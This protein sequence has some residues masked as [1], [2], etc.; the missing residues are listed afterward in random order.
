ML[1]GDPPYDAEAKT[2]DYPLIIHPSYN[3]SLDIPVVSAYLF[4]KYLG[5]LEVTF[6]DEGAVT[7]YAGN[8]IV[9]DKDV[10]KGIINSL[11]VHPMQ[12]H[13][14]ATDF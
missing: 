1:L 5:Y 6:D 7:S 8:P 4:G 3:E 11:M 13:N 14:L 10:E 12:W 2:G 9:L